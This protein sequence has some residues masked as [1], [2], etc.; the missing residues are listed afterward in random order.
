MKTLEQRNQLFYQMLGNMRIS[1]TA[2]EFLSKLHNKVFAT[3]YERLEWH[4]KNEGGFYIFCYAFDDVKYEFCAKD[5]SEFKQVRRIAD[6]I[7][8]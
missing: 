5:Y 8:F 6:M 1:D 7:V 2:K 4:V 3:D